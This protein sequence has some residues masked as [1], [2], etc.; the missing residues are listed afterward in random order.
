MVTSGITS[1][2]IIT[3][4]IS[5]PTGV[6]LTYNASWCPAPTGIHKMRKCNM[7]NVTIQ[8]IITT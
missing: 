5:P 1:L 4:L 8:I 7:H 2:T 3:N 6:G